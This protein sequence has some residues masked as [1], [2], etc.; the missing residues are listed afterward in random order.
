MHDLPLCAIVLISKAAR[1]TKGFK[2][3]TFFLY[4]GNCHKETDNMLHTL[5]IST[6]KQKCI[7]YKVTNNK[8]V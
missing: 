2:L 7:Q 3:Q 8:M 4:T 5:E 1:N 6:Q